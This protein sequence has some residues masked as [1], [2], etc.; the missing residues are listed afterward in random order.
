MKE[1]MKCPKCP[2]EM[3]KGS[4]ESLERNFACTRGEPNPEIP[5]VVKVQPYYCQDC[6]YIEFYRKVGEK[7]G[8]KP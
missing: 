6:G 3:I 7:E 8:V 4:K 2:G 5:Q 1:T